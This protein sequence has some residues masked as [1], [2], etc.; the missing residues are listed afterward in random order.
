MKKEKTLSVKVFRFDPDRDE[1]PRYETYQVPHYNGM[2]VLEV[3]RWIYENCEPSLAFRYGCRSS[4]CGSCG[5]TVN[6]EPVL[7][8]KKKVEDNMVVE[9]LPKLPI[10]RDLVVDLGRI[11]KR[12]LRIRPFIERKAMPSEVPEIIS[13]Q[14]IEECEKYSYCIECYLCT[15][16]CPLVSEARE[17]F[18]GPALMHSLAQLAHDP[19]DTCDREKIALSEGVYI[20]TTCKKCTALCPS[21]ADPM[22]KIV[23]LRGLVVEKGNVPTTIK[24]VLEKVYE[25][26]NPW[27]LSR[28]KRT[29]W[30]RDLKVKH[31]SEN[32]KVELLYFVGC[33]PS[34]DFRAQKVAQAL[35]KNLNALDIDFSIL[36]NMENCC[37]NEVYSLGE[38][39]LFHELVQ[40]NL[41]LFD[42]YG[43]NRIITTSPHCYNSFKNTYGRRELEVQHYTQ[44]FADLIDKGILRFSGRL[45]KVITYHDPCYL[46]RHNNILDEPRKI[47]ES[48][49][50]IKFLEMERSRERSICCEGGGGRMWYEIKEERLAQTRVREAIDIGAEILAVACPFCLLTLE[51]AVKTSGNENVIKVMDIMELVAKAIPHR[52]Y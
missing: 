29:D 17:M 26:G 15:Q 25:Y 6:G 46:G 28:N 39:G 14:A 11:E 12:F 38:R 33:A 30:A 40:K 35:V 21:D 49:P 13:R 42:K 5:V 44:Y 20:C 19:R 4:L 32:E 2:T 10:I 48:I 34:Y 52:I 45:N 47:I 37:G 22:G 8:C 3:L 18:G 24:D 9:P 31:V 50:G 16:G 36:G 23:D 1:R 7:A 27:G 43:I 41:E 51:D